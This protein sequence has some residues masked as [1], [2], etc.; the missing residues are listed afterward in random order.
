L[1]VGGKVEAPEYPPEA[2]AQGLT[3]SGVFI[4]HVDPGN[5]RVT[6]VEVGKSTGEK[7][8]DEASLKKFANLRF[9]PNTVSRVKIPVTFTISP[10]T[11]KVPM[12]RD[13]PA[14]AMNRSG[15]QHAHSP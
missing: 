11:N 13:F 14:A 5:G 3:G 12:R 10:E 9:K 1:L 6:S 4:L 15:P 8:L 2:R 7:I